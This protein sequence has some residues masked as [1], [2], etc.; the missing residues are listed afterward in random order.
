MTAFRSFWK[1]ERRGVGKKR[2]QA[3]QRLSRAQCRAIVFKREKGRCQQCQRPVTDDVE[4]WRPERAH[5]DE[6]LPR[7]LGG[8]PVD[9][10]NC[11]LL[12]QACHLPGGTHR[13]TQRTT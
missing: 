5:V 1:P 11:R 6:I 10:S 8:S 13:R 9:P 3:Q 12:C 7:S 2:K 4:P